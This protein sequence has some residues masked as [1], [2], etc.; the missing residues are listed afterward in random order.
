MSKIAIISDVHA[1]M[2]ALNLILK[3][4]EKR[5]VDKIICLG[6]LVTKYFYPSQVVDAIKSSAD[7]VVK[8][9]CDDLV[10]SNE[11]YK[12]ARGKLGL[13]N[14]EYLA[15]LPQKEQIM[16]NKIL[17]NLYHATPNDLYAMFNP[18][19]NDNHKTS[20]KDKTITDYN[21]MFESSDPQV[22]FNGHTHHDYI[23]VEDGNELKIMGDNI[24]ISSN[25]RAIINVGSAGEH[26]RLVAQEDGSHKVLINPYLTYAIVD[27][28]N[29]DKGFNVQIIR[30][31][32]SDTLKKVYFNMIDMQNKNEAPY[33][34]NDTK[35]VY[36]SLENMKID[37]PEQEKL[38]K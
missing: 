4:I 2:D 31:P 27:D 37:V 17:V 5:N 25:D 28:A 26:N 30:V 38:R 10:S 11:K 35:K 24:N 7:I 8:G 23:G 1:N 34:P 21:Q 32:Y 13:E 12:F 18:L 22:S 16:I 20:Y 15:N 19:F 33:S 36:E 3:D 6:D 14:I 29:L 9:N